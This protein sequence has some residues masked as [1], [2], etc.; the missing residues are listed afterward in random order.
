M[1][2]GEG[3]CQHHLQSPAHLA[4]RCSG[5]SGAR[6][7][8][9][10]LAGASGCFSWDLEASGTCLSAREGSIGCFPASVQESQEDGACWMGKR[11]T[12]QDISEP[13]EPAAVLHMALLVCRRTRKSCWSKLSGDLPDRGIEPACP[14]LQVDSVPPSHLGSP[15][16]ATPQAT[17][18]TPG[19][20]RPQ[21]LCTCS[22]AARS[23]LT[24]PVCLGLRIH[25]MG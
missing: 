9:V 18:D 20:F 17:L 14:A 16:K 19:T 7:A 3:P 11:L 22:S 2:S 5:S 10:P 12:T 21:G 15:N 8:R 4:C 13:Q 25:N 6:T 23:A 24:S 1:T